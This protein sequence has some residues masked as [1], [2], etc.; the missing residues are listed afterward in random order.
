MTG[1]DRTDLATALVAA[2]YYTRAFAL[3]KRPVPDAALRLI[4]HLHQAMSSSGHPQQVSAEK[5]ITT[6]Q[7]AERRGCSTRQA[8]RIAQQIGHRIGNRWLIPADAV[9]QQ[10]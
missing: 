10:E 8:R 1:L 6:T 4:D 9:E 5:W 2:N 7:L 3:I